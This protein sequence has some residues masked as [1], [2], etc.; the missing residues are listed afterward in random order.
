MEKINFTNEPQKKLSYMALTTDTT[1]NCEIS[2]EF[3]LPDYIPEIRKILAV[4]TGVLPESKYLSDKGNGSQL[5]FGGTVTYLVIYTDDEGNLCSTPLTSAYETSVQLS[6]RPEVV[7]IDTVADNT[8]VRVNAPRKLT[9][10]TRLKNKITGYSKGIYEENISSKSTADEIYLQRAS[11]KVKTVD[12]NQISLQNVKISDKFD[13]QEN[14]NAKPIW[15]DATVVIN[16]CKVQNGAVSVRGN[17]MVKCV[18]QVNDTIVSLCKDITV[19][20]EIE[21]DKCQDTAFVSI[22]PRCVMLAISN[23]L[24][25][26]EGQLFFDLNLEFEG[27]TYDNKEEYVTKDC[28]STKWETETNYKT[29][30][31]YSMVKCQNA[32]FTV[33]ES[34]KRKNNE[35]T[36]IVEIIATPVFEKAEIKGQ[37]SI[38]TG[39][40]D[41][42]VIGMHQTDEGNEYLCDTFEVPIK[43]ETDIK[44]YPEEVFQRCSFTVG[45]VSGRYDTEKFLLN[46]E[47]FLSYD[48]V[49]KSKHK[50]L[51]TAILKKD[52]EIKND[53]ACVRVCFPTEDDSLWEIAKKYHTTVEKIA[54][55][56]D[57]DSPYEFYKKKLII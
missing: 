5:D 9:V 46:S 50:V 30:D 31:T 48:I 3:D 55:Q 16:D 51:D 43:Y 52:R 18:C 12:V 22:V 54:S 6:T 56:N 44:L 13:M 20:E 42:N 33:S 4:K 14:K 34:L 49:E 32:S 2:E 37:K 23:E 17:G 1:S 39:K 19:N 21:A 28:Y 27:A 57:L 29:I 38:F 10:K 25:D 8:S 40:L 47:I 41:V 11:E 7:F 53:L 24:N 26:D 35:A 36:E 45:K 15:C